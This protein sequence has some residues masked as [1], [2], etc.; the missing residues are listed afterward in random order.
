MPYVVI[1][2]LTSIA[3]V[4][5]AICGSM[6]G[7]RVAPVF[8][9]PL[10]LVVYALR[11]RLR[12]TPVGYGLFASALLL[13]DMGAYGFYQHSPTPPVSFDM[14]V[15]FYFALVGAFVL[16]QTMSHHLPWRGWQL[17]LTTLLLIMG[18]GACHEIMEYM[19]YLVLGEQRGMLKTN[20]YRFDNERDLTCNL[21]GC[22]VAMLLVG[23]IH[24]TRRRERE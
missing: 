18:V 24:L 10:M 12:L 11:G 15:H 8:L 5:N 16:R 23:L 9:I 2:I 1:A 6:P 19:T 4:V 22:I 7:Y 14:Y 3:F 20:G 17:S 21:A 13:H